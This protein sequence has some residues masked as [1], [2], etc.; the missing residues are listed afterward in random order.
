MKSF[1]I[2]ALSVFLGALLN[3]FLVNADTNT[4]TSVSGGK[5][6]TSHVNQY[7][8]AF[9]QTIVPRNSSGVAANNGGDLG[10]SSVSWKNAHITTGYWEAGDIKCHH[11]YNGL[12][13]VGQGWML[14]DGRI[15]NSTNYDAE[16]SSGDFATFIVSTLLDGKRLPN[17]NAKYITGAASTTQDGS[18][19]IT[20]VGNTSNVINLIHTHTQNSQRWYEP[21]AAATHELRDSTGA[22]VLLSIPGI[23]DA[24][25]GI[26][27]GRCSSFASGITNGGCISISAFE[28]HIDTANGL[29]ASENIR[30]ESIEFTCYMR[31]I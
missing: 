15:V 31:I 23:T 7:F 29:S 20:S 21:N 26:G 3:I 2:V 11:T 17:L 16:H 22:T 28:E 27:T 30:P 10:T 6:R 13:T 19:A 12:L 25:H 8:Q 14:M 18:V 9:A 1:S 5:V 24:G 4:L